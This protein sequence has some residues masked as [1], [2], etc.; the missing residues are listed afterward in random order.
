MKAK[1]IFYILAA[2]LV[3]ALVVANGS[4]FTT[5]V[6]LNLLFIRMQAPLMVLMLLVVA[7]ILLLDAGVHMMSRYTWNRERRTLKKDLE[8]ALLRADREEES[9]MGTL[10]V[11][12]EREL[13]A[14]HAQLSRLTEGQSALLRMTGN[15][16]L[17]GL[18]A[19]PEER[20]HFEPELIS[21]RAGGNGRGT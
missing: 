6:E 4:L 8:A 20:R 1:T 15:E 12:M 2:L 14:I 10:R 5:Q 13:A 9:R 16:T 11:S 7:V 19:T 17:P 3:G 21:P 18:E